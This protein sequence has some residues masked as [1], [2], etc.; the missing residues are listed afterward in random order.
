MVEEMIFQIVNEK[1]NL[2][3]IYEEGMSECFKKKS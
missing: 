3:Q 1:K 2:H